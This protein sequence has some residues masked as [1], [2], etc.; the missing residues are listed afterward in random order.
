M[1]ERR[2]L[3]QCAAALGGQVVGQ[4]V[5]CPGPGHSSRDRSLFVS[6][7]KDDVLVHSYAGDDWRLCKDHVRRRLGLNH[8][9]WRSS[10]PDLPPPQFASL[11]VNGAQRTAQ[12]GSIWRQ[13]VSIEGT[14]AERYLASRGLSYT[15]EALRWHPQCP[16]GPD[17]LGCMVGLVRNIMTNAPQA[18]HRTALDD[19]GHKLSHSGANGRMSLGLVAGGAVKLTDDTEVIGVLAIGEGIETTLSIQELPDLSTMPVWSVLT[20]GGLRSFPV[21]PGIEV[22]WLAAD[23]DISGTGQSAALEAGERLTAA[24][25]EAIII[26]PTRVGSDINDRIASHGIA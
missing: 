7:I 14:P 6:F 13:A 16:F 23:N 2:S 4:G 8:S 10:S 25:T 5:L 11:A 21:L 22:V 18:V 12:A 9:K 1:V 24:G 26:S 15:G 19:G 17:R 20:A 3:Q